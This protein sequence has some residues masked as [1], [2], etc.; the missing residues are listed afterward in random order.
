MNRPIIFKDIVP[1]VNEATTL[2]AL[3]RLMK[4]WLRV[5]SQAIPIRL[6]PGDKSMHIVFEVLNG[7][8]DI[9]EKYTK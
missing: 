6:Q 8:S 1:V 9:R 2:A 4:D 5:F 3:D 7:L